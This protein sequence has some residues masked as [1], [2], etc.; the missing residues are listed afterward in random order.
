MTFDGKGACSIAD[1]INIGGTAAA[2]VST[3]GAYTV[4]ANGMG[5]M[6]VTFPGDPGPTPLAF[7]IADGR[8]EL[9]FIRTDLGVAEGVA[10][11]Q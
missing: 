5:T 4:A 2:R 9:R 1:T 10:T 8:K 6:T 7:V 11:R 3:T